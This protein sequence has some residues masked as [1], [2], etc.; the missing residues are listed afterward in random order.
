VE[1]QDILKTG[2]NVEAKCE[3]CGTFYRLTPEVV[4]REIRVMKE[5]NKEMGGEEGK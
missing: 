1:V 5:G 3:F 4:E 2:E